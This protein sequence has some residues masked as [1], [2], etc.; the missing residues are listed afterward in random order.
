VYAPAARAFVDT[1]DGR[2]QGQTLEAIERLACSV[3]HD[4]DDVLTTINQ[5]L[6]SLNEALVPGDPRRDD[7]NLLRRATEQ[8]VDLTRR[9]LE[10]TRPANGAAVKQAAPAASKPAILLAEDENAIRKL[11]RRVLERAGYS[12]VEAGSAEEAL[13]IASVHAEPFALLLTDLMLPG[14]NG[15]SLA[16]ALQTRQ[17]DL[18]VICM[19]G[20]TQDTIPHTGATSV[21]FRFLEKPFTPT[22]L[23]A[24]VSALLPRP[25]AHAPSAA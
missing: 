21:E 11:A 16:A 10:Y 1:I 4:F 23:L 22:S 6:D 20:Y 15:T 13:E 8:G 7:V 24:A 19:S 18:P 14:M 5:R 3:A 17:P 12:V 9:L 25:A 2:N